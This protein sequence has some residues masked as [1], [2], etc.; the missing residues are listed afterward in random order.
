MWLAG[1][2]GRNLRGGDADWPE[3]LAL[4]VGSLCCVARAALIQSSNGGEIVL[5]CACS[6]LA[7]HG[8]GPRSLDIL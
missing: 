4:E 7:T 8:S 6:W 5:E 3:A 1:S 2:V